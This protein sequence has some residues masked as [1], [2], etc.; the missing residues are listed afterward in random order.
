[1]PLASE[2]VHHRCTECGTPVPCLAEC[3]CLTC[4]TFGPINGAP[5]CAAHTR[6]ALPLILPKFTQEALHK[7][8]TT[9][10]QKWVCSG[11][12][13]GAAYHEVSMKATN[14]TPLAT[15]DEQHADAQALRELLRPAF[16][17]LE[18]PPYRKFEART[19]T[20]EVRDISTS[21]KRAYWANTHPGRP[22]IIAWGF[23]RTQ[24]EGCPGVSCSDVQVHG[25]RSS[26]FHRL[27]DIVQRTV[28]V[29]RVDALPKWAWDGAN[30]D[31]ESPY[32]DPKKPV[33]AFELPN[34]QRVA[35]DAWAALLDGV[36]PQVPKPTRGRRAPGALK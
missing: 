2:V 30:L 8:D 5:W 13:A 26:A 18:A 35:R 9:R 14:L 33:M 22:A 15:S 31:P 23:G 20:V 36:T 29:S 24:C 17:A 19:K 6:H 12:T 16:F 11:P 25:T 10:V 4:R 1:M 32:F 27:Y 28:E 7:L 3:T 21:R 34:T